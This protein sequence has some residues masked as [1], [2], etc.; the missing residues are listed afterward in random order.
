MDR[1]QGLS[2]R[3]S[4]IPSMFHY[5][6]ELFQFAFLVLKITRAEMINAETPLHGGN[7]FSAKDNK[8]FRFC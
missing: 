2:H 4:T 7:N 1:V 5:F 8:Q 6:R 3:V